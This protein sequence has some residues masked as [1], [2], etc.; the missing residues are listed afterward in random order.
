LKFNKIQKLPDH[1][2]VILAVVILI[3]LLAYKSYY[4]LKIKINIK[5]IY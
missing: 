4:L 1:L 2:Q 5:G 3:S